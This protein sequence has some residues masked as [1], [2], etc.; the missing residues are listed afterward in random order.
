MMG[1]KLLVLSVLVAVCLACP[2]GA[3]L[4]NIVWVSDNKDPENVDP[5]T[6]TP[7]DQVW[8]DL[9]EAN[10]YGVDKSFMNAE[11]RELD[12]TKI[13]AL[14]SADLVIISRNTNSGDYDDGD[15]IAQWNSLDTS[16]MMLVAHIHRSSRWKW[17]NTTNTENTTANMKAVLPGHPVFDGVSLDVNN[18]IAAILSTTSV[19]NHTEVGNGTLIAERA[20][21]G[22][23][24]IVEWSA[25][26]EFYDGSGEIAGG[27]RMWFAAG[28]S[29][30]GMDGLY[31]L[32]PDGEAVFLNAVAYMVPEPATI[33]LLGLGALA[34]HRRRRS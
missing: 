21:N 7:R 14:N 11:A 27:P 9:L 30:S 32:T 24:W 31:N 29:G 20:D 18:E 25:G 1:K 3:A 23:V 17:L 5:G 33:A 13:A 12:A 19:T 16:V 22:G 4:Q 28:Q 10:G 8:T 6:S 15:E 2:A 26:Q 34:L